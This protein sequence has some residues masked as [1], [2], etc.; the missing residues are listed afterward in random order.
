MS[1][2]YMEIDIVDAVAMYAEGYE[3]PVLSSFRPE[4]ILPRELSVEF[5]VR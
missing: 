4:D 5:H 3:Y 2:Q 1:R